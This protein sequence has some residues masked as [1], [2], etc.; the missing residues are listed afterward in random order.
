MKPLEEELKSALERKQAPAGFTARVMAQIAAA[1][2]HP[3]V[4][5]TTLASLFRYPR[6]RWAA[7][8]ALALLIVAGVSLV[9]RHDE[10]VKAEAAKNQVMFALHFAGSKLNLAMAHA[11]AIERKKT[12]SD[13]HGNSR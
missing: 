7:T 2:P 3:R 10:R 6:L 5:R 1:P 9:R 4:W 11:E 13:N 8:A 12:N